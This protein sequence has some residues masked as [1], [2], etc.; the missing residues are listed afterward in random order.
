MSEQILKALTKLFAIISRQDSGMTET[1]RNFVIGFFE[2]DLDR[3]TVKEYVEL[4]DNYVQNGVKDRKK[5]P[6]ATEAKEETEEERKKR[7]EREERR[8]KREARK[9][10]RAAKKAEEEGGKADSEGG[11]RLHFVSPC[12]LSKS[13]EKSTKRL[14]KSRK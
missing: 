10:A 3:K 8:R 4:Y 6:E 12:R 13:V 11:V 5:K 2:Q 1:E 9:A 14:P 7:E